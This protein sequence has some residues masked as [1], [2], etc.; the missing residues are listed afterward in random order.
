MEPQKRSKNQTEDNDIYSKID[1][2]SEL[3]ATN[4]PLTRIWNK[5]FRC[6]LK[7][8]SNFFKKSQVILPL[9]IFWHNIGL[10]N[11]NFSRQNPPNSSVQAML[12]LQIA[13]NLQIR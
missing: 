7:Y 1:K 12:S 3:K 9:Q 4:T 8:L 2:G 13:L 11:L 10:L 5:E 6:I